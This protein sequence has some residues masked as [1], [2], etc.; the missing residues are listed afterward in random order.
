M[1]DM[2]TEKILFLDTETTGIPDRAFKWD[3]NYMDY[4]YLVQVAWILG[5]SVHNH[6]VKPETWT[7]PEEAISVHGITQEIALA[8]GEPL[9]LILDW[10][11]ADCKRAEYICG[12]NV[13]FDTAIIKANLLREL[14][15]EYYDSMR[16]GD[17]LDKGKRID[18]MRASMKWVDARFANGRL[19]FPRLEELYSKCF[20]GETYPAHDALEDVKAVIKCFP[21][22]MQEKLIK[23][24]RKPENVS[25]KS[26]MLA[27]MEKEFGKRSTSPANGAWA[28]F[29]PPLE[30][31]AEAKK[32]AQIEN[33]AKITDIEL[34]QE[35]DF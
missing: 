3:V 20:P 31:P 19:K 5:D 15:W 4:P 2:E 24:E 25:A 29:V 13:H 32:V 11:I 21:V 35:I 9:S 28:D 26:G 33:P 7:I 17:A 23:F 12:H 6:I 10:L 14:G 22:L 27:E 16:A 34:L 8:K 30:S 1:S 18:T